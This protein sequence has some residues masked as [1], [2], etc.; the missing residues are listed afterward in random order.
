MRAVARFLLWGGLAVLIVGVFGL[1]GSCAV[2]FAED[3]GDM[4]K[5]EIL[6][7]TGTM[8]MGLVFGLAMIFFGA[9]IRAFTRP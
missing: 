9:I 2:P 6:E 5:Q 7:F 4:E 8:T 1:M 3:I